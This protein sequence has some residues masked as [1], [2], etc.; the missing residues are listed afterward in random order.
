MMLF[1]H[2]YPHQNKTSSVFHKNNNVKSVM[3]TETDT[4]PNAQIITHHISLVRILPSQKLG[5]DTHR[6]KPN[7]NPNPNSIFNTLALPLTLNLTLMRIHCHLV[8]VHRIW[9]PDCARLRHRGG[10]EPVCHEKM[11][12]R[13][14]LVGEEAR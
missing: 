14:M 11:Q 12:L 1:I 2:I 8:E 4:T 10:E 13:M 7:P 9:N 3:Q 5:A 6:V